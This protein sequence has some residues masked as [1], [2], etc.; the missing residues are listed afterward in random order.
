M[1]RI[2]GTGVLFLTF[3]ALAF[4][5]DTKTDYDHSADFSKYETFAWKAPKTGNEVVSNSLVM[6]RIR[7][8]VS[9]QLGSKGFTPNTT[10]PDFYVV[11]HVT[12]Q[13]IRDV[14]YLPPG[15]GWR[16][17]GWMG[18]DVIVQEYVKGTLILDMVDSKTNHLVWRAISTDTGSDLLDVQSAKNV[19][20]MVKDALE[21]FPPSSD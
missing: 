9:E 21:H 12:A 17:W 10:N 4:A 19:E 15:R 8:A 2:L 5:N 18:S 11:A 14:D 6:S 3:A 20:K 16:N 7:E 13:T 1:K